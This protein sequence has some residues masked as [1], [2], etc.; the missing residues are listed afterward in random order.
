MLNE[1]FYGNQ[2]LMYLEAT[3]LEKMLTDFLAWDRRMQHFIMHMNNWKTFYLHIQKIVFTFLLFLGAF[4]SDKFP[5]EA[6]ALRQ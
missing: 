3:F 5:K 1:M 4:K 2:V 6:A